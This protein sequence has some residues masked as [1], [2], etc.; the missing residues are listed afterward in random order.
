MCEQYNQNN[1]DTLMESLPAEEVAPMDE[2]AWRDDA[3]LDVSKK[4]CSVRIG[5]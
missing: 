2:F 4:E 3:L 1:K 5:L